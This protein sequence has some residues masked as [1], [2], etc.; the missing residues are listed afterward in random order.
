MPDAL[1]LAAGLGGAAGDTDSVGAGV[2]PGVAGG[3]PGDGVGVGGGGVGVGVGVALGDGEGAGVGLGVGAG[4]GLGPGVPGGHGV[5]DGDAE[6]DGDG[7]GVGDDAG[8]GVGVGTGV[9]VAVGAGVGVAV[10][11]AVG[12]S[13]GPG[14]GVVAAVATVNEHTR[15][16]G[17]AI[18]TAIS[19]RRL[20]INAVLT[21]WRRGYRVPIHPALSPSPERAA[22]VTRARTWAQ[23]DSN[24]VR[25]PR[26]RKL[27]SKHLGNA[28]GALASNC[29][30][31]HHFRAYQMF[32]HRAATV[33][34]T[35]AT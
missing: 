15:N 25:T 32:R 20:R 5:A 33:A 34:T 14:V 29:T 27:C 1:G 22:D 23:H 28:N 13:V 31:R 24:R 16:N 26:R 35:A 12:V 9:G 21:E 7:D 6:G 3:Q 8:V 4:V 2:A 30:N 10:G 17:T 11:A 18:A 19:P